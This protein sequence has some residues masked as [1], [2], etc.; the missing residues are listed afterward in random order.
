MIICS[1]FTMVKKNE[2][3]F[4]DSELTRKHSSRMRT[5]TH[6]KPYM[7]QFQW[8]PTDVAPRGV[9][10]MNKFKQI[11]SD[12]HQMSLAVGWS[13]GL[14]SKGDRGYLT[15][16][17]PGEGGPQVWC[18]G[19]TGYPTRCDLPH[20]TFDVIY[21]PVNREMPVKTLPFRNII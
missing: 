12:H 9:S 17:F 6:W 21:P 14:M 11:L 10:E 15:W 2:T 1:V 13:P 18:P 5:T 4:L 8:P 19:W 16:P 7:L 20:D 3:M